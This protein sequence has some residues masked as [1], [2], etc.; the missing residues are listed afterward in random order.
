MCRRGGLRGKRNRGKTP[1]EAR[2]SRIAASPSASSASLF[3]PRPQFA[4]PRNLRDQP[5]PARWPPAA[6]ALGGLDF[7]CGGTR[8]RFRKSP[9]VPRPR[10]QRV[11]PRD[12]PEDVRAPSPRLGL[13][14]SPKARG[15]AAAPDRDP[16]AGDR[17]ALEFLLERQ[18]L[19]AVRHSATVEDLLGAL[20]SRPEADPGRAAIFV[21]REAQVLPAAI[22]AIAIFDPDLRVNR[23]RPSLPVALFLRSPHL[24]SLR[25]AFPRSERPLSGRM[26]SRS[27]TGAKRVF[28]SRPTATPRS[29][30]QTDPLALE[31][32]VMADPSPKSR[33]TVL[34]PW[35]RR[36]YQILLVPLGLIAADSIYL[37]SFTKYSSFFM[38][39]LLLHLVL[40]LLLSIPFFVFAFTHA[41]KM[42]RTRNV[43]GE[44]TAGL[45]MA[46]PSAIIVTVTGLLMTFKGATIKNRPILFCARVRDSAC[47][48]RLRPSPPGALAP[49]GVQEALCLGRRGG[50]VPRGHGA[51]PPD[52]KAAAAGRQPERRHAVLPVVGRDVRP[53]TARSREALRE[54]LLPGVPPAR[55]TRAGRNRPTSSARSTTPSTGARS[56]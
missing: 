47:A 19:V 18:F 31:S 2:S 22:R 35:Q 33:S 26:P 46:R 16:R 3:D 37:V 5:A 28:R 45:A 20:A 34:Q 13:P 54:R 32:K 44:S 10:R 23:P 41:R 7:S 4:F 27:G 48:H 9:R 29:G 49:N 36:I 15:R 53:G 51:A 39:M 42:I 25:G 21:F 50:G 56:S 17:S 11:G 6:P 30:R 55:A 8:L 14:E 52:R 43:R 40:G 24:V 1:D 38:A 12:R